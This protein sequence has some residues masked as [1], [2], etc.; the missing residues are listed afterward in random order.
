MR[1]SKQV[2]YK[3]REVD[4]VVQFLFPHMFQTEVDPSV[5]ISKNDPNL[6]THNSSNTS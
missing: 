6:N 5:I 4:K 3:L 1:F 2:M